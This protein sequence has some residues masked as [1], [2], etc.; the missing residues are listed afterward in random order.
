VIIH[1]FA[2]KRG[3]IPACA[4]IPHPFAFRSGDKSLNKAPSWAKAVNTLYC[5]HIIITEPVFTGSRNHEDMPGIKG[6]RSHE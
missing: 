5:Q 3:C 4:G 2:A 6:V 1:D